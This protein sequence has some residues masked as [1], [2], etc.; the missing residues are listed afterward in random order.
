MLS[1][2]VALILSLLLLLLFMVMPPR[3]KLPTYTTPS[4][5]HEAVWIKLN[6]WQF[7]VVVFA[8]R[9]CAIS[10]VCRGGLRVDVW[11]RGRAQRDCDCCVISSPIQMR[12][13]NRSEEPDIAHLGGARGVGFKCRGKWWWSQAEAVHVVAVVEFSAAGVATEWHLKFNLR[14]TNCYI[15]QSESTIG[16]VVNLCASMSHMKLRLDGLWIIF[17]PWRVCR[18]LHRI[19]FT[20]SSLERA[21]WWS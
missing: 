13:G 2:R 1:P 4:R 16:R 11:R 6:C 5:T 7:Q 18:R 9:C 12:V 15:L 10:F 17:A 8:K 20:F 14:V 19:F 21:S 3:V